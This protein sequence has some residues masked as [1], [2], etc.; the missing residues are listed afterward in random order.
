MSEDLVQ[1]Y[2]EHKSAS[3]AYPAVSAPVDLDAL[4]YGS[5]QFLEQRLEALTPAEQARLFRQVRGLFHQQ[6]ARFAC[7]LD[8]STA[9]G[10]TH[11]RD[12]FIELLM[13]KITQMMNAERSTLFLVDPRTGDLWSKVTQGMVNTEIT[14]KAGQGVAGWVAQSGKSINIRD[15]YLDA[16][17][18][19][20]VDVKTGFRT[21]SMVCQPLRNLDGATIGVVQVLNSASGNFSDEDENLLSAIA[22][23]AAVAIE[24]STLYL[25][26]LEKNAELLEIKDKLEHKI[27]ELDLLFDIQRELS[28]PSDL[29]SLVKS[30]T[31]KTLKLINGQCSALTL[32]EGAN[33]RVYVLTDKGSQIGRWH[34]YTRLL[35]DNDT[36]A[37][38]V[39]ESG[40]PYV[41][42]D[43]NCKLVPGP[44]SEASGMEIH[45]MIAVPLF[46]EGKCIGALE[47]FNLVLPEVSDGGAFGFTDDDVKV[48]SL[49]AQQIASTV[50]SRSRR[51]AEEK[52]NRLAS[53]GQMI[54]GVLHDFKTPFAVISGYVQLMAETDEKTTRQ[55]FASNTVNQFKQLNQMTRELLMF[56]RGDTNI[57]L[58]KVFVHRF[59]D[60]VAEL[61][62]KELGDRSVKLEIA[63][64]Y[65]GEARL[66]TVK[67]KRAILNLA[68]NA[69]DA[70]PDG[71]VFRIGTELDGDDQ[72][73]FSFG[74]TGI[75]IPTAIYDS[76]FE[77]FVTEGKP[78]GTGLGLAVVKK[79]VDDH[80]G[81][82]T[83]ESSLGK[84]TTFFIRIP[85]KS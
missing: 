20:N 11:N 43:A 48:L 64:K 29:D 26:M 1:R 16:R 44:T 56:A 66:D 80:A 55:Q 10:T 72:L 77:S 67:M 47:V 12:E 71:G 52:E 21:H 6:E 42:Q 27:A 13:S 15:A 70:M 32:I 4:L 79:I 73:V 51:D 24:N 23:Q 19:P 5:E 33:Q 7:M 22:S 63:L 69:A 50:A 38:R 76:L 34:F 58:R 25:S 2:S 81:T 40:E 39:I 68:R 49:I 60:E 35:A 30:I 78:Q 45:N 85:Y 61:L 82:I 3:G 83:F 54:S 65:R 59:M 37:L 84:G 53:I 41:C 17:F 31:R 9:L 36:I 46:D 28:R 74:D 14:L 8:I 18:D 62:E 57:L 75:G